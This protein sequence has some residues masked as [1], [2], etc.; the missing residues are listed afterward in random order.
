MN[1]VRLGNTVFEGENNAYVLED[2]DSVAL[3][4][5]GIAH[6]ETEQ[7]LRDGLA[8]YGR[9]FA[10]VDDI[11]LTHWHHD[12]SDLA[13]TIQD[14]GGATV[15]VHEADATLVSG[16][17]AELTEAAERREALFDEWG[18]PAEKR[19]ELEQYVIDAAVT[20]GDPADVTPFTDGA[21]FEAGGLPLEAV[22]LPGHAKGL[23][24][25]AF[26]GEAGEEVFSGDAV[27]PKYTPN[28][29]GA[30]VRVDRPLETYANSLVR[31][32]ERDF[33]RAWPGH[34]DVIED[35]SGRA[36]TIL[37][38]HRERTANVIEVL[39]DHGPADAWTVSAHLFGD[40]H[41][42]HILHGPGEAYAHLDHLVHAD[43]VAKSGGEYELVDPDVDVAGLFPAVDVPLASDD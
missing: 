17:E 22:D 8:D 5:T 14:E 43:A 9:S 26:D 10:E 13:A 19:E 36:A 31:F 39:A 42:I 35:P 2:G 30:D 20:S 34:R 16:A 27:L 24:G 15:H 40:L 28:V 37:D 38:H 6:P 23:C 32:I 18:I 12:H 11:F 4:D 29:G 21:T 7:E 25:F 33:A 1:H 3:V 41:S